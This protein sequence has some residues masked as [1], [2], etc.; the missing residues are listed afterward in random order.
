[1]TRDEIEKRLQ[2]AY[3]VA[4]I[5]S[6]RSIKGYLDSVIIDSRPDPKRFSLVAKPWQW[7]RTEYMTP[8]I[9]ALC[10]LRPG[11]HGPRNTWETMP[12]GHDKTTGIAR[13]CNWV[14]AFSRKPI[15]ICAAASDWDQAAL[16]TESMLAE[17][18][19]N[20][21]LAKR[22][23]FGV[24][25]I[26]G[27]GGVLKVLTA[28]SSTNFGLRS[29]LVVCDEVTHW[30][31]RDLWDTLWSGRQ[32]RPGSV[33]VVITNAGTLKS[34]QHEILL[35]V[36]DDPTWTVYEAPGQLNSWM[37]AEALQRD[38]NLLPRGM[39]KRVLDNIWIDPSEESGYLTRPEIEIGLAVG[40]EI[41]AT[42]Q[43]SGLHG[44]E[45]VAA[46]DYGARRDRTAMCVT[47]RNPDGVYVLDTMEVLQGTPGNPVPIAYVESWIEKVANNF[48]NP[49]IVIDP[50]QMEGTVQKFENR[51]RVE[52]FDARSGKSNYEMAELLRSLLVNR[53][54]AFY[55]N[56]APLQVGNRTEN[57]LDE[58]CALII[59]Q[60]GS[61]YRFDH[62]TGMHDDRTVSLGMCLVTL[63][64]MHQSGPWIRVPQVTALPKV[65][66]S[67]RPLRSSM[68][69]L[70]RAPGEI[71]L[72]G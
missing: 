68:Y 9:E 42:Y 7:K 58:M 72:F 45:Y 38:R 30:K 31:K 66:Y 37:D 33:F 39:A 27:P 50:W 22:L 20:P 60:S 69:G 55:E 28:D 61:V 32:K 41:N 59:R 54:L 2:Q 15:E 48:H 19:L 51:L 47:H 29:D 11:F 46:V 23:Q 16:I 12:R 34:W 70:A 40:R 44:T 35:Q 65:D 21:W 43:V 63:A 25:R 3:L 26:K 49:R 18:K 13:L 5:A 24:K 10:G 6:A 36:K 57:L 8:P 71:K 14:L 17:A 1:M 64:A 67:L 4:E 56:P 52:R 53:K 62:S